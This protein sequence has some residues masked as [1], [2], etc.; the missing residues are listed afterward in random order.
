MLTTMYIQTSIIAVNFIGL[1]EDSF[2]YK[3]K[4]GESLQDYAKR[5]RVACEVLQSHS[6][7]AFPKLVKSMD[8]VNK[9]NNKVFERFLGYLY[10]DSA[11]QSKH[12]AILS[13]LNTQKSLGDEQYPKSITESNNV[14][15]NHKFDKKDKNRS[16]NSSNDKYKEGSKFKQ[17]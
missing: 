13:G 2:Q 6:P 1:K 4:Q 5:F 7:I 9:Y 15:S 14:L 11:D 10:L 8:N 12:D 16:K 3:K 17:R